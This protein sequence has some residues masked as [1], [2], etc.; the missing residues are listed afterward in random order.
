M[1]PN[2]AEEDD[3]PRPFAH[4]NGHALRFHL[5][6]SREDRC[7]VAVMVACSEDL[8]VYS[9]R[10]FND[11]ARF[12]LTQRPLLLTWGNPHYIV[13]DQDDSWML[14]EVRRVPR[15]EMSVALNRR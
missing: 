9:P 6:R 14:L 12:G 2:T 7:G 8:R 11:F 3:L 13:S 1:R 4:L 10:T 15:R 5:R